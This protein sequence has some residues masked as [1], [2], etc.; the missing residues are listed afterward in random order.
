MFVEGHYE[1]AVN[2]DDVHDVPQF[3]LRMVSPDEIPKR[4]PE[5]LFLYLVTQPFKPLPHVMNLPPLL[6]EDTFLSLDG[7]AVVVQKPVMLYTFTTSLPAI[8]CIEFDSNVCTDLLLNRLHQVALWLDTIV[9]FDGG[10]HNVARM[11]VTKQRADVMPGMLAA[12]DESVLFE[13]RPNEVVEGATSVNLHTHPVVMA[14]K[15]SL[16]EAPKSMSFRTRFPNYQRHHQEQC[17]AHAETDDEYAFDLTCLETTCFQQ[18][19]LGPD[20]DGKVPVLFGDFIVFLCLSLRPD[21]FFKTQIVGVNKS[22]DGF[23]FE[24]LN[25]EHLTLP[26]DFAFA[27]FD[28]KTKTLRSQLLPASSF[29]YISQF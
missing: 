21:S 29:Q 12:V 13:W 5:H 7:D 26:A 19:L 20:I 11:L 25:N 28:D 10:S 16:E 4:T 27:L 3:H 6:Q 18:P 9:S 14:Y 17:A 15:K 8:A 1:V 22:A 2:F 23:P 24:L